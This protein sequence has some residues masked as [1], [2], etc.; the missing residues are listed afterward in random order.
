[1][2]KLESFALS[3]G[4]KINRP[5]ID[6]FFYPIVDK[7]YI[8]ISQSSSSE[9]KS[10]DYYDDVLFHLKPFLDENSI[11]VI[12]LGNSNNP[13]V[14]YAKSYNHVNHLHASYIINKSLMYL[15]NDNL[16]SHISSSIGKSV[17]SPYN[18]A[19]S[20][21]E[22]P[23][24]S[25]DKKLRIINPPV[26]KKPFFTDKE[27][28]KSINLVYPEL[29]ASEV[30]DLLGLDNNLNKIKTVFTGDL[31]LNKGLDIIP[32]QYDPASIKADCIPNVRM[33]KSF[34][35]NFLYNCKSIDSF[36]IVTD[37]T[38]P[39]NILNFLKDH[40]HGISVFIDHDTSP[41]DI[42]S[43][44]ASG[45]P[46]KILTLESENLS[47]LRLKFI[48][49][50]VVEY[51]L[52]FPDLPKFSK[53]SQIKFLSKRNVISEGSIYNSYY[54]LNLKNNSHAIDKDSLNDLSEDIHFCRVFEESS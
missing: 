41:E 13:P 34:D 2:H 53:K 19:Y 36:N 14:Y 48:D 37:Q 11:T 35:L 7:K 21:T 30:L 39:I 54:S 38:I 12:E 50:N 33:D 45:C 49:F 10:Y 31:Y 6:Q 17:V 52:K 3:C 1:M 5:Q 9:S 40:I 20:D 42:D 25:D 29:I 23:Y 26:G 47:D 16:Y 18:Y 22:K 44:Q 28:P 8:C 43:L 27:Y 24:W 4:S 46:L 15:G 32:G 51:N